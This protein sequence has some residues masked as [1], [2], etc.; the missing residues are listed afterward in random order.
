MIKI[1]FVTLTIFLFS[2][3]ENNDKKNITSSTNLYENIKNDD[4]NEFQ[5]FL[6]NFNL[7]DL[8]KNYVN[9]TDSVNYT[10]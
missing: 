3:R 8:S 4:N 9:D 2:C 1:F 5:K 10:K 7:I 6:A